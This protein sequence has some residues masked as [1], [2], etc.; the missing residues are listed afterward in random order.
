MLGIS[1]SCL[2]VARDPP[3]RIGL[4]IVSC[5]MI[6]IKRPLHR[7]AVGTEN[8]CMG[9]VQHSVTFLYAAHVL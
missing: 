2:V 7:A 5:N 8:P 6:T 3:W 1:F 4:G 9:L